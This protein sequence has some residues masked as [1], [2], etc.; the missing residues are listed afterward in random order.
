[1]S[2]MNTIAIVDDVN[3]IS[4]DEARIKV[5]L[6]ELIRS[7]IDASARVSTPRGAMSDRYA[8]LAGNFPAVGLN[9]GA[10][11]EASIEDRLEAAAELLFE[12]YD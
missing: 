8:A 10:S 5:R 11:P 7:T 3:T 1:M 4:V 6:G 2:A 9:L 12:S